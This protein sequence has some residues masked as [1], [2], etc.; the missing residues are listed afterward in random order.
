M[1]AHRDTINRQIGED[2][3]YEQM[4]R[5][6]LR[7]RFMQSRQAARIAYRPECRALALVSMKRY[8]DQIADLKNWAG[9]YR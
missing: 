2:R 5:E 9:Q 3:S 1:T 8:R 4:I 7:R 6:E